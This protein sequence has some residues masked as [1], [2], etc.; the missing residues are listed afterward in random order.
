MKIS[1]LEYL[2]VLRKNDAEETIRTT[3]DEVVEK[4]WRELGGRG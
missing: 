3:V 1:R 2:T 4:A